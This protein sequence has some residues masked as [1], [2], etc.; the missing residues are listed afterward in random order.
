MNEEQATKYVHELLR[1]MVSRKGMTIRFSETE[2]RP[3]GR[4]A[5]VSGIGLESALP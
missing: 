1:L 2:V 3:M 5:A 4:S